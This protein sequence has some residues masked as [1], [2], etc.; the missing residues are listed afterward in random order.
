MENVHTPLIDGLV[1]LLNLL[2]SMKKKEYTQYIDKHTELKVAYTEDKP[3]E[4]SG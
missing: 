3:K 2:P 4:A 1:T